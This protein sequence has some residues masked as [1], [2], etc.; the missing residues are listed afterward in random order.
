MA[1]Y[2]IAILLISIAFIYGIV[3]MTQFFVLLA[4]GLALATLMN[5]LLKRATEKAALAYSFSE[6]D[7]IRVNT[8]YLK[9]VALSTEGF[10]G[11]AALDKANGHDVVKVLSDDETGEFKIRFLPLETVTFVE[12]DE[13]YD[14]LKLAVKNIRPNILMTIFPVKV[15]KVMHCI[16]VPDISPCRFRG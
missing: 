6:D 9:P 1:A 5:I 16:H 4:A 8:F 15:S 7:F 3:S 10:G 12:D 13:I 14:E 11:Y 2:L